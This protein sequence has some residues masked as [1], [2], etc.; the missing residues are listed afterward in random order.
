MN[1]LNSTALAPL[2]AQVERLLGHWRGSPAQRYWRLWLSE[3]HGVLPARWRARMGSGPQIRT[4]DWPLSL[5]DAA[6]VGAPTREGVSS[7]LSG[8]RHILLLPASTVLIQ[9]LS[10]PVIATR[11]LRDVL[12]FELDKHTPFNA[13][14]LYFDAKVVS[15]DKHQAKVVLVAILRERLQ[16][17]LDECQ[18]Q[19]LVLQAVDVRDAHGTPLGIDLLPAHARPKQRA[20]NR[21]DRWLLAISATLL[22]GCMLLWLDARQTLLDDM[23]N[24]VAEQRQQVAQLQR[25]RSELLNTR[26]AAR[27]LAQRKL[28]QPALTQ[29]LADLTDCLGADTWLEQL[30]VSDSGDVTLSG[31]SASASDLINR[32]K[33]CHSLVDAQFQGIIQPD[34]DTG[35]D[36]FSLRAHLRKEAADAPSA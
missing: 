21:I 9:H 18:Q 30:E 24:S 23:Q 8:A 26:G 20:G 31:Q 36:H 33:G 34:A 28:A 35:K 15:R 11:N 16:A 1:P 2:R 12:G 6:L 7:T 14:Q 4:L 29:V 32:V 13:T 5:G 22:L 25:L 17:I 3:L 19:G 27:Y 10:V